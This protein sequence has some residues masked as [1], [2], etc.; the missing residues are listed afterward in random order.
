MHPWEIDPEQ[1]RVTKASAFYK[2]R[3]YVNLRNTYSKLAKFLNSFNQHCFIT[4]HQYLK[5]VG[6]KQT[7]RT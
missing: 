4:C 7:K 2:F 3:H 5:A 1:P 6:A